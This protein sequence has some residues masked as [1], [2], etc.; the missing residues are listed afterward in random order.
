MAEDLRRVGIACEVTRTKVKGVRPPSVH[1]HLK[2]P[3][4]VRERLVIKSDDFAAKL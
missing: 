3:R 4:D 2:I 1:L